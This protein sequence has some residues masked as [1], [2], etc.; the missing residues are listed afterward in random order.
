MR[1]NLNFTIKF[2][3]AEGLPNSNGLVL[4]QNQPAKTENERLKYCLSYLNF[5]NCI[6]SYIIRMS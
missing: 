3:A 4:H 1:L 6:G 5:L 2:S